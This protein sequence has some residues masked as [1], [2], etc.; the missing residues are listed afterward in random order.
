[1]RLETSRPKSDEERVLPLIN[2]VFLLLIFI[3]LAGRLAMSD[4]FR[5]DPPRSASDA[6]A[7]QRE[8]TVLIGAKGR[9][10][11]DGQVMDRAQ[12]RSA[13]AR[14]A[15]RDGSLRVLVRADGRAEAIRVIAVME[16]LREAGVENLNLLTLPEAR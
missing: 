4:P 13:V 8:L 16:L 7:Q 2:V 15:S 11:L 10:A 14:R 6:A 9:L 12:I 1:M 3:M 5:I